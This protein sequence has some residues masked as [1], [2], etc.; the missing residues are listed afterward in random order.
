MRTNASCGGGGRGWWWWWRWWWEEVVA[1]DS[2]GGGKRKG[3]SEQAEKGRKSGRNVMRML[4]E[5]QSVFAMLSVHSN[6][7]LEKIFDC[8]FPMPVPH[9]L[10]CRPLDLV[11]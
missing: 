3:E 6:S 2:K 4:C 7:I 11:I 9:H 5:L 10:P 8:L 1:T